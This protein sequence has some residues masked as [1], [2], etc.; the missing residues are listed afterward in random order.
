[1][2]KTAIATRHQMA[3]PCPVDPFAVDTWLIAGHRPSRLLLQGF[4]ANQAALL[5][6][7]MLTV[8]RITQ[9]SP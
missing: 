6:G 9:D 7:H 1:M 5:P 8:V 4:A 3:P 2:D